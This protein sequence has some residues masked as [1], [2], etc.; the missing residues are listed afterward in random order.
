M[1]NCVI[2]RFSRKFAQIFL[3]AEFVHYLREQW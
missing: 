3:Y 2:Y 1:R